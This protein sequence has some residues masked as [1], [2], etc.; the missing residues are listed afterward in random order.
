MSREI[1]AALR[2]AARRDRYARM[3]EGGGP[4]PGGRAI[5]R[6]LLGLRCWWAMVGLD[7]GREVCRVHCRW[8]LRPTLPEAAQG[9]RF[10]VRYL[11][12]YAWWRLT[13]RRGGGG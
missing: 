4:A 1:A 9:V 10:G 12:L 6:D 3:V 2:S 5:Y 7:G 8:F 13:R 11:Y